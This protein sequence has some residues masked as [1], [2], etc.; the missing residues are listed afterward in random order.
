MGSFN[1]FSTAETLLLKADVGVKYVSGSW[2]LNHFQL[3]DVFLLLAAPDF[4]V[5]GL[6]I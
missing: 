5:I 3:M 4:S 1:L 2:A 6:S